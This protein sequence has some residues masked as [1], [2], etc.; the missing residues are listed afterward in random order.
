M[1]SEMEDSLS[2]RKEI[3]VAFS[4]VVLLLFVSHH[5]PTEFSL[6]LFLVVHVSVIDSLA[7]LLMNLLD[8]ILVIQELDNQCHLSA[9]NLQVFLQELVPLAPHKVL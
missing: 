6:G 8:S 1:P 3:E 4:R 5:H 7:C 2:L 9:V